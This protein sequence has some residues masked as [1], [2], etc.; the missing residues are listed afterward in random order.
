[1]L[2][3]S[4]MSEHHEGLGAIREKDHKS[5]LFVALN[6]CSYLFQ[7]GFDVFG[8]C[9]IKPSNQDLIAASSKWISL[10]VL[11]LSVWGFYCLSQELPR[12]LIH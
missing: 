8:Y 3:I 6:L 12:E 11:V 9:V 1:M 10:L 7:I 4:Q 2:L 5:F